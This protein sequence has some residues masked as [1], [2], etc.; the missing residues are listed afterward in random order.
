[1][2]ERR[3][4]AQCSKLFSKPPSRGPETQVVCRFDDLTYRRE[5]SRA[6][7]TVRITPLALMLAVLAG[8]WLFPHLRTRCYELT[9]PQAALANLGKV[10]I[11]GGS[12]AVPVWLNNLQVGQAG[13]SRHRAISASRSRNSVA[14]G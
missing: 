1:M 10:P 3:M 5:E 6:A 13:R 7:S 11:W 9:W 12:A 4:R 14:Q 8:V 2:P